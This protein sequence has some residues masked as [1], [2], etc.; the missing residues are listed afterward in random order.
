MSM[1]NRLN[2]YARQYLIGS[3]FTRCRCL[4]C[5]TRDFITFIQS[6]RVQIMRL[7]WSLVSHKQW[8]SNMLSVGCKASHSTVS[9]MNEIRSKN[10]LAPVYHTT[11]STFNCECLTWAASGKRTLEPGVRCWNTSET[12]WWQTSCPRWSYEHDTPRLW[13]LH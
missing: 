8:A 6:F 13:Y 11:K 10:V 7:N 5:V 4:I 2:V 3:M 9:K 12:S 1:F